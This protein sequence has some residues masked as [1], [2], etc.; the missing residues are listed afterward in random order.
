MA[1]RFPVLILAIVLAS[2]AIGQAAAAGIRYNRDIR[3]ILSD[4]CFFCHGPDPKHREGDLRLDIREEALKSKAFIPGRPDE[5]ELIHRII[6]DDE[7]DLMPPPDSKKELSDREKALLRQW[8]AEGAEYE[9]HWAYTPLVKPPVPGPKAATAAPIDAFIR[10]ELAEKGIAPSPEAD[11]RTLIRRVS[12]DLTGLPPSPELLQRHLDAT[13]RSFASPRAYESLVD[14]LLRSPHFGERWAVWWL[15]AV[16][17]ADT[18]GF[19]GDQNQR[20]FPYRDYVINAFNSNKRFDQFTIEQIAGDLLPNPTQEQL[21]ATGFN[22]LNMMT[23]EGGAQPKEYLAKYQADRVRTIGSAWLG[24]GMT[25]CECHDH[26]YDPLTMRDFY[27]LAAFFADVKQWGVYADY[28]YTPNPELKGWSNDHP[29]PP[30]IEVESPFLKQRLAKLEKQMAGVALA[31]L[32]REPAAVVDKWRASVSAF[33]Q[34][35][36]TGWSTPPPQVRTQSA[37][38]P[39]KAAAKPVTRTKDTARRA[40]VDDSRAT[41]Q[42]DGR[43]LIAARG[44]QATTITFRPGATRVAAVRIELLP[45]AAHKGTIELNGTRSGM[46]VTPRFSLKKQAARTAADLALFHADADAKEPRFSGTEQLPGVST[47]WKTSIAKAGQPQT[48]VWLLDRPADLSEGDTLSVMLPS[49]AAGCMRVSLSA[50]T[51]LDPFAQDWAPA[52]MRNLKSGVSDASTAQ[53]FLLQECPDRELRDSWKSLFAQALACSRGRAWTQVTVALKE[54]LTIRLLP[55]GNWQDESGPVMQPATLGIIPSLAGVEGRRQN[56]IDFARWLCS[57]ENPLTPRAFVNRLWKQFFGNA[58]SNV[59]DDLGAQGEPPSHPELLDWLAADFRDNG[60]D[61]KRLVQTIVVSASYR[62]E[63]KA[64]PELKDIDPQ[65]RLLGFQNPRRLDA[66]FVRDNALFI[67]GILNLD[68]GGPSVKPYQPANYYENLQFP[69]RDYIADTDERQWRRG[70]YMHWQRT[71]LHPMLANFDAPARDEAACTR[72][73]SNTPQQA[74]TLLNDPSFVEAAKML[75]G[76][77][78]SH[79]SAGSDESRLEFVFRRALARFPKDREKQSLVAFLGTQRSAFRSSPGDAQ[80]LL[81]IGLKPAPQGD[82][83]EL[84]AWTSLCRVVLNLHETI[85][86]Y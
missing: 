18:V 57:R 54:P 38:P 75:A 68:I 1:H 63:S 55:R 13:G 15:D 48:S 19:H 45:D 80:K 40:P 22:R 67:A 7:D 3:P 24:S 73:V 11:A 64:R 5:S 60:W 29:F 41:V 26:K 53:M 36:P 71:F 33:L 9:P 39:K 61:F 72:N 82:A 65:N 44:A 81:A 86:R 74:L 52:L 84:A 76:D 85:T 2:P 4:K 37:T 17:F 32:K 70:L 23:R 25:C 8:I 78:L 20:I 21:V 49:H 10:A 51:P 27:S 6:T 34:Q 59:V 28:G 31:T 14:E 69:N 83:A 56:R 77:V 16:R 47:G 79:P 43:I 12:L 50:A 58:L 30:E 66:E 46:I 62:Q 42:P 35:N